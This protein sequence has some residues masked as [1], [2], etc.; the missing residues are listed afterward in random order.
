ML[1]AEKTETAAALPGIPLDESYARYAA[2]EPQRTLRHWR[3]A[4][5]RDW[6]EEREALTA[7]ECRAIYELGEA[8]PDVN[9]GTAI[10]CHALYQRACPREVREAAKRS[11]RAPVRHAASK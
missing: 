10:M 3:W 8:E 7:E 1:I 2:K 9:L 4:A 6:S 11:G 5:L